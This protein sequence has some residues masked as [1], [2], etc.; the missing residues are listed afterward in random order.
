MTSDKTALSGAAELMRGLG[1]NVDGP[2]RWGSPVGGRRPGVFLVELPGGAERAPADIVAVRRWVEHV[3]GMKIDGEAAT[4]HEIARRLESFWL[5]DEPI[6]YVGRSARSVGTRVSSM[7]ATNLGD[8]KPYSGG[9]WLKALAALKDLRVWWA[10]TEAHEEY[11]DALLAAIAERN[12]GRA[13]FANMSGTDGQAKTH[14]IDGSI[15]SEAEM[16]AAGARKMT[17][18]PTRRAANGTTA[19]RTPSPRLKASTRAVPEPTMLSREGLERL[20]AELDDLRLNKRPEVIARVAIA[21]SHGDLKE[22]AE[23]E[24]ARKEQSFMEGRIQAL[25]N[26]LRTGVVVEEVPAGEFARVGSTVVVEAD[27][28]RDTY[29]LVSS[30]E[31]D[32]KSGRISDVS[33]V[34]RALMGARAGAEVTVALPNGTMRYSVIEVR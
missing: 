4:A 34:G 17:A 32:P 8:S 5:P 9:H 29:L 6:L 30:A 23:Y 2:A 14:G 19:R 1:L 18:K 10:D 24:Y 26:L 25:E 33:P 11:V 16:A 27:G 28:E 13:P 7:Y 20:T 15:L 31:A 3:P 12:G 21:R 22:N